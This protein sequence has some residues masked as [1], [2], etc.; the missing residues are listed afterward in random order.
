MMEI[1]EKISKKTE[2]ALTVVCIRDKLQV[3]RV[4]YYIKRG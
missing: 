2:K 3:S 1:C 4:I